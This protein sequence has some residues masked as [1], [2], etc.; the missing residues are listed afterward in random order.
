MGKK[1]TNNNIPYF[2]LF[3][4]TL[5]QVSVLSKKVMN[6]DNDLLADGSKEKY[7]ISAIIVFET[8]MYI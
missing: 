1:H 4:K 7:Y 2:P 5:I 6:K 8:L 3:L